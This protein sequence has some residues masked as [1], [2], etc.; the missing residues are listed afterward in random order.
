MPIKPSAKK[1]LRVVKRKTSVNRY[2][3]ERLHDATSKVTAETLPTAVSLIDKAV[4]WGIMHKNKAARL[5][6]ALSKKI[7]APAP[8]KKAAK[9][10]TVKK[11]VVKK[12]K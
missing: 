1:A 5:K 9:P 2:R 4:K 10:K 8:E 3:K 7:S 12:K 6:S 11:T